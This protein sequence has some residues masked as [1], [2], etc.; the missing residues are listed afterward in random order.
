MLEALQKVKKEAKLTPVEER[1]DSCL[2][3]IE[4]VTKR[5]QLCGVDLV[6]VL[7]KKSEDE[8]HHLLLRIP[9]PK[10]SNSVR[11]LQS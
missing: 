1:L 4:R 2:Q 5:L 7:Q 3:F 8:P 6:Q 9:V 10:W 11:R